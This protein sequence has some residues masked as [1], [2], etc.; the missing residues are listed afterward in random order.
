[1]GLLPS[2]GHL[3]ANKALDDTVGYGKSATETPLEVR[4]PQGDI[5]YPGFP[6]DVLWKFRLYS[7]LA[8]EHRKGTLSEIKEEHFPKPGPMPKVP[9]ASRPDKSR[10]HSLERIARCSAS[11]SAPSPRAIADP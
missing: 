1:M 8:Q 9:E 3:S 5:V 2:L 4:N 11:A 7:L 10:L 6:A